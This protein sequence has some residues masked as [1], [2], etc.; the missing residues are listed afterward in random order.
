MPFAIAPTNLTL[1]FPALAPN[2]PW[3]AAGTSDPFTP[4]VNLSRLDLPVPSDL[5][6]PNM[7]TVASSAALVIGRHQMVYDVVHKFLRDHCIP[8]YLHRRLHQ[9]VQAQLIANQRELVRQSRALAAADQKLQPPH[10]VQPVV[11]RYKHTTLKYSTTTVKDPFPQAYQT[12][13]NSLL[14]QL[15]DAMLEIEDYN[16]QL[17]CRLAAMPN[18]TLPIHTKPMPPSASPASLGYFQT[19]YSDHVASTADPSRAWSL[20]IDDVKVLQ[21]CDYHHF[22]VALHRAYIPTMRTKATAALSS[23]SSPASTTATEQA[24]DVLVAAL[25]SL[26]EMV[27]PSQPWPPTAQKPLKVHSQLPRPL[28]PE[29]LVRATNGDMAPVDPA[30]L[31]LLL[32]MG[33]PR[34]QAAAA[35]RSCNG[36]V[37]Q[38]TDLLLTDPGALSLPQAATDLETLAASTTSHHLDNSLIDSISPGLSA[39][40]PD[41]T[42][43]VPPS[44]IPASTMTA[45]EP[46]VL[47]DESFPSLRAYLP[48]S[49]L[50]TCTIHL[51]DYLRAWIGR[52]AQ[53]LISANVNHPLTFHLTDCMA[54]T[55]SRGPAASHCNQ[56]QG[57]TP[58]S[59]V[60]A[61]ASVEFSAAIEDEL[62]QMSF[63]DNFS[64]SIGHHHPLTHN[65]RLCAKDVASLVTPPAHPAQ[66]IA[67]QAQ[68][69]ASI[70]SQH[71]NGLVLL[72]TPADWEQLSQHG[73]L[74]HLTSAECNASCRAFFAQAM[75]TTEYHFSTVQQQLTRLF[76]Q[77]RARGQAVQPGDVLVTRHSN[78]PLVHVVFYL[79]IDEEVC[80]L[81]HPPYNF[82]QQSPECAG[83]NAIMDA[84]T[85]FDVSSLSLP[86]Y[87]LPTAD[88]LPDEDNPL[89]LS[90]EMYLK[91]RTEMVLK[92][93]KSFLTT[94]T[95]L[96]T[97]GRY[98]QLDPASQSRRSWSGKRSTAHSLQ[99]NRGAGGD[100][101][102]ESDDESDD[103]GLDAS[104]PQS[105]ATEC[106]KIDMKANDT[107][108]AQQNAPVVA[109]DPDATLSLQRA[110]PPDVMAPTA[111]VDDA[112]RQSRRARRPSRRSNRSWYASPFDRS[113]T[114]AYNH[115]E[116]KTFEFLVPPTITE[117]EFNHF[118]SDILNI[119]RVD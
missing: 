18:A 85:R 86:L 28:S 109:D 46:T 7:D 1:L 39:A 90:K 4:H 26:W 114:T 94:Y 76:R 11:N 42:T 117:L 95:D 29:V 38:A 96:Q 44:P 15:F 61:Q 6:A 53:H 62:R 12:L 48:N 101:Q 35:L 47:V 30:A 67:T 74:R 22:I 69:G 23:R 73:D 24:R 108:S 70:Y 52:A 34:E 60:S 19:L 25:Q 3:L 9:L 33:F 2:R 105:A 59:T 36:E 20:L 43:R 83:L 37:D 64:I 92:C 102:T 32:Q 21:R 112:E 5:L 118:R 72:L 82:T 56:P 103:S 49:E 89:V 14:T 79:I 10:S 80:S 45:S 13:A 93:I 68:T 51:T 116:G 111:S 110:A 54:D 84:M 99:R 8:P 57:A 88:A 77:L 91:R 17:L 104:T 27:Y 16:A 41:T 97:T 113:Q 78:V 107:N 65:L 119:F 55:L 66:R 63:V 106:I 71:L 81:S 58:H 100:G 50:E 87:L 31:G 75:A 40:V 115:L 98:F